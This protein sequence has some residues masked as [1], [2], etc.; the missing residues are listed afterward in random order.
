MLKQGLSYHIGIMTHLSFSS[1]EIIAG[2]LA[3]SAGGLT[4]FLFFPIMSFTVLGKNLVKQS[5]QRR[6][7][8]ALGRIGSGG[9]GR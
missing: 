8:Q 1:Q 2:E 4:G 3:M 7:G 5:E 9:G 6:R